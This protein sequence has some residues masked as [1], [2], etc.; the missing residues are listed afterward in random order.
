VLKKFRKS[1]YYP[2]PLKS[3]KKIEN[4][5]MK[6]RILNQIPKRVLVEQTKFWFGGPKK[7]KNK[8]TGMSAEVGP[9]VPKFGLHQ[10]NPP[11]RT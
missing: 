9:V 11:G 1:I 2:P 7:T 3:G 10:P 5:P 6:P 4:M 8:I